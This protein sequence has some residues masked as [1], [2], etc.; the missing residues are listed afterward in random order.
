M[1]TGEEGLFCRIFGLPHGWEWDVCGMTCCL[2]EEDSAETIGL[3]ATRRIY[4]AADS[5]GRRIV[6]FVRWLLSW[7]LGSGYDDLS[8]SDEA[9]VYR[10]HPCVEINLRMNMGVVAWLLTD[11][12]LA[13]DAEG[14]FD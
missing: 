3:C 4:Q 10:I 6:S 11:R 1:L 7:I 5:F 12:Y 13:A 9:P 8:F 2:D 14:V